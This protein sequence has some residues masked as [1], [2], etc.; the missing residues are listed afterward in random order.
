V[1]TLLSKLVTSPLLARII[2]PALA[3]ALATFFQ[4]QAAKIEL[5]T[6]VKAAKAAKTSEELRLASSKLS[7]ASAR[8]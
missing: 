5:R 6:A 2:V 1:I 3:R 8:H 4:N 7:D